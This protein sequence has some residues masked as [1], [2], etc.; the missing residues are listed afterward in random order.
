[1]PSCRHNPCD[2]NKA[3]LT[4]QNMP[5]DGRDGIR[6]CRH[7][8]PHTASG[9]GESGRGGDAVTRGE[10]N[11]IEISSPDDGVTVRL[12]AELPSLT[13]RAARALLAILVELTEVPELDWL[14]EGVSD[15]S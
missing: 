10:A 4:S 3:T 5:C 7:N 6:E 13:P 9:G 8:G 1:M 2:G 12:P 15:D 14:A 11:W